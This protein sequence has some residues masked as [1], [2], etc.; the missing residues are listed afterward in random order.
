MGDLSAHFSRS[1]LQCRCCGRL[2]ID[3]RLLDGLEKLRAQYGSDS[4]E[5]AP[6]EPASERTIVSRPAASLATAPRSA[7]HVEAKSQPGDDRIQALHDRVVELE[8]IF[9]ELKA[10]VEGFRQE[11]RDLRDALGA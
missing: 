2:Q 6:N 7:A 11:F 1:E 5:P 9:E 3:S 8:R 4:A 10:T